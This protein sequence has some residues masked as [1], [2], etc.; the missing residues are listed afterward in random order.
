M[1]I[2]LGPLLDPILRDLDIPL[3]K[4]GILSLGFF[5]GRVLGV[6]LLSFVL[7]RVPLKRT[8]VGAAWVQA[9]AL[10]VAG[11]LASSLWPLFGALLVAGLTAVIPNAIA[12]VWV[13]AHLREGTHRAMLL[14]LAF[15]ALGVVVAPL[16]IGAALSLGA[17]WRW[18][19][20]GEAVFS[21]LMAVALMA[22][23]LP[24]VK[25][26][27]NLRAR[28]LKE[29]AGF[30]PRLL[31][32]MLTIV[33]LYVGSE[34]I[35]GVWLP[36]FEIDTH[37][38]SQSAAAI[39]VTLLWAGITIG[40]Y[41]TVPLTRWVQPF[42]LLMVFAAV[43]TLF[44]LATVLSPTLLLSLAS[45]FVAGLGASVIFPL[46]GGYTNRFPR[47]Y[48]GVAYSGIMLTG[49]LGS[50][51]FSYLT[52]PVAEALGLRVA[53][54]LTAILPAVVMGLALVLG[55]ISGESTSSRA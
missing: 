1:L 34:A 23:R 13:G 19:F 32:L 21:A 6:L 39:S 10:V 46:I 17:T 3:A 43:E 33:F 28:H 5:L 16:A 55:R 45:V 38:A 4:G 40:R 53:I 22:S 2:S 12:G 14:V 15:F 30:A 29:M 41:L 44:I 11:L 42:R 9:G 49:T 25:G 31:A 7:A 27:E 26:R 8:L 47:W 35:L 37:G 48:A 18:V 24:D 54:G 51:V 52:G 36:K 20:V 50:A